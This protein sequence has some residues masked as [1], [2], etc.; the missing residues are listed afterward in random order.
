M[1]SRRQNGMNH[2]LRMW[3]LVSGAVVPVMRYAIGGLA[4]VTIVSASKP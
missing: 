3:R 1:S 4:M 2:L